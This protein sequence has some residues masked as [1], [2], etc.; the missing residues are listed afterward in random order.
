MSQETDP[1]D[2]N[3]GNDQSKNIEKAQINESQ[4]NYSERFGEDLTN[5]QNAKPYV[6]DDLVQKPASDNT[7]SNNTTDN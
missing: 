1:K 4:K 5:K 7:T 2:L 6:N 3:K